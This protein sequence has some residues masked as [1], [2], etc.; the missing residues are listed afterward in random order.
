M[1]MDNSFQNLS[2]QALGFPK[3]HAT[4]YK[5]RECKY[6]ENCNQFKSGTCKFLHGSGPTPIIVAPYQNPVYT[7]PIHQHQNPVYTQPIHQT[8]VPQQNQTGA[9]CN[10]FYQGGNCGRVKCK[11]QHDFGGINFN[12]K[13]DKIVSPNDLILCSSLF[14]NQKNIILVT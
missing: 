14:D 4:P 9:L 7:Q 11:N 12:L 2:G 1:G 3:P 8:L 10:F 13:T 6:G 5:Q